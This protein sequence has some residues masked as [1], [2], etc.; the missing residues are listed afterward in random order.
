MGH[1]GV[2]EWTL[3]GQI[4]LG[5]DKIVKCHRQRTSKLHD[6]RVQE[7]VQELGLCPGTGPTKPKLLI[8]KSY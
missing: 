5:G 4:G 1:G 6:H 8:S 3:P 7:Q 2:H